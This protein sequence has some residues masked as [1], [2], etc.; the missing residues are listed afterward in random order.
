MDDV[1]WWVK[2]VFHY[3]L[4]KIIVFPIELFWLLI[5]NH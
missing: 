5:E 2:T 1:S 3:D 4:L